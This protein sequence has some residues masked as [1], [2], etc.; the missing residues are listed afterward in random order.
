MAPVTQML[1]H[2]VA[3][4]VH[5]EV[6]RL[7]TLAER[8]GYLKAIE[9]PA[10]A[11]PQC[12]HPYYNVKFNQANYCVQCYRCGQVMAPDKPWA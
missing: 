4:N 10:Q 5:P 3:A 11:A 12:P 2:D 6:A 1:R 8:I 7:S 9:P